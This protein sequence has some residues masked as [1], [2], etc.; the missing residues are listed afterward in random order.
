M[1]ERCIIPFWSASVRAD[2]PVAYLDGEVRLRYGELSREVQRWREDLRSIVVGDERPL[3]L[4]RTRN[5]PEVLAP[6][7]AALAEKVPLMLVDAEL[8]TASLEALVERYRPAAL[9]E[10]MPAGT[11]FHLCVTA[12][13]TYPIDERLA[14][15]LSTSGSTGSPKFVRLSR[16]A[17]L[18]NAAAIATVLG[19]D[20]RD[21][22]VAHLELHY[23]Y[24][25][26]VVASHLIRGAAVSFSRAA[27]TERGFWQ[28]VRASEAT[29][30]PGVPVHYEIMHR[31][32]PERLQL[33]SV[34]VLTQAGGRLD[35]TVRDAMHA[36]AEAQGKRFFVMYGQTEA[37]PR[38]STLAHRDYVERPGSVGRALPG[39]HF[40][41]VRADGTVLAAGESGDIVYR[42]RNVM[43][44]Y[45]QGWKDLVRGDELGG[46][47][48]TG[49]LGHLDGSGFLFIDGRRSREGKVFGLRVN[50][51]E[52]E[53]FLSELGP[54]YVCQSG[55][56]V[57]A[58]RATSER[59]GA[60][61]D[62][63]EKRVLLM[64]LGRRFTVPP[65]AWR[66]RVM[67]EIPLGN[68]GKVDHAA[69]QEM[70]GESD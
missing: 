29:H 23:S 28:S 15:L 57:T 41:I 42:G 68:R 21:I 2:A 37:A 9:I 31:L 27:F 60:D 55:A 34:A 18:D 1:S 3:V 33:P 22:G 61:I 24:G 38:M 59:L 45:A 69:L 13:P 10:P 14:L 58:V 67:R 39:G 53:S 11:A 40:E 65:T 4:F 64:H 8:P 47:L 35:G 51:D 54:Y 36:F 49:D 26:S 43:Q 44:G 52:I 32:R 70:L 6:L 62:D 50:L 48:S 66:F 30:F 63:A 16:E 46:R 5:L 25:W 56:R 12:R 17:L 7:T 20:R 19:I